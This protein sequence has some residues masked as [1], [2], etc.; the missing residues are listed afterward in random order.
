MTFHT[1]NSLRLFAPFSLVTVNILLNVLFM[2]RCNSFC[3]LFQLFTKYMEF[4]IF[5]MPFVHFYRRMFFL[6]FLQIF[7][8]Q[9]GIQ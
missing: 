1:Y 3:D 5:H 7:F 6:Q 9:L 2:F 4:L 8:H